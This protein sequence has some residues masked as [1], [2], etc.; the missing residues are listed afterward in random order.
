MI[1]VDKFV[2]TIKHLGDKKVVFAKGVDQYSYMTYRDKFA[3]TELPSH[4]GFFTIL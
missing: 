1:P 3:E 2:H 4:R